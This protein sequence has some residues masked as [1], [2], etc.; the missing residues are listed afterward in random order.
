ML[1]HRGLMTKAG[2]S[3]L[4]VTIAPVSGTGDL[5]GISGTLEI[6]IEG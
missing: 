5:D 1:V 3:E 6:K 4:E 2:G